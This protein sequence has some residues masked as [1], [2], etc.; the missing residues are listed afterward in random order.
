MFLSIKDIIRWLFPSI[1]VCFLFCSTVLAQ[2]IRLRA[3]DEVEA[4]LFGNAVSVDGNFALMGAST[5]TPP[6]A[7]FFAYDGTSWV[8]QQ[9][10]VPTDSPQTTQFGYSVSLSGD[11]A[12]VGALGGGLSSENSGSAYIFQFNGVSWIEMQKLLPPGGAEDDWFGRSVDIFGDYA[13]VGAS[14]DGEKGPNSGAAYVYRLDGALWVL[15]QKVVASDGD[16]NSYF[17]K[18]VA[19]TDKYFVAG[20]PG[21]RDCPCDVFPTGLESGSTYVFRHDGQTWTEHQKLLAFDRQSGDNFGWS[22]DIMSSAIII[23]A[24]NGDGL[25]EEKGAAYIFGLD[26]GQ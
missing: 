1:F 22:V 12:I 8:Q 16:A 6:A 3:S 14:K 10:I 2:E 18:S 26:S 11:R 15:D 25:P 9:K 17:G 19:V 24:P 23:G 7:Y 13:I 21:D 5:N 4:R 20:A